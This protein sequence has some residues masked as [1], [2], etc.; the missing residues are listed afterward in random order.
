MC[1][2][3]TDGKVSSFLIKKS[4]ENQWFFVVQQDFSS[5]AA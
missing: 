1:H 2:F 3:F 4:I 5:L